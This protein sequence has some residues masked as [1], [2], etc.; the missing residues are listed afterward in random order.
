MTMYML[1]SASA[2]N[3]YHSRNMQTFIGTAMFFSLFDPISS[4]FELLHLILS[5]YLEFQADDFACS[6]G[7]GKDLFRGL[8]KLFRESATS[9]TP[10][11]VYS[12]FRHSH[13][14]IH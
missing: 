3:R 7:L 10:D 4:V 9:M 11:P 5:R 12:W 6:Q 1:A 8:R 2:K 13:P 14:T